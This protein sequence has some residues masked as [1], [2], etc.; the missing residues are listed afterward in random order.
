MAA[1]IWLFDTARDY[2][3]HI[4]VS[5]HSKVFTSR[6]LVE[7]SNGERSHSF[8]FPNCPRPQI[9][10]SI[11]NSSLSSFTNSPTD[12]RHWPHR[13]HHSTVAVYGPLS[14]DCRCLQSHDLATTVVWLRISRS[15]PSNI[16]YKFTS[17]LTNR[18]RWLKQWRF[19]IIFGKLPGS[20]LGQV[21]D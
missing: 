3:L 14:N 1:F 20:N 6:C 7:A 21:T 2:T 9:P 4:T 13:K 11:S 18:R 15:L 19:L 17:Y 16:T 12:S 10:A 5:V 8:G